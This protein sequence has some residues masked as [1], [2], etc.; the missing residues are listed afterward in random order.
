MIR[1]LNY[2][3][4]VKICRTDLRLGT[5]GS[6]GALSFDA[7]LR[8][9]EYELPADAQVFVE[10]YRQTSWMR[11]PYGTVT[12]IQPPANRLL[13]EFDSPEGIHFRIK[14]T[15][16]GDE[17]VLLAVADRIPLALPEENAEA[18]CLL[19][20]RPAELGNEIWQLDL[21]DP[22]P[23]LLVNHAAAPDWRQMAYS[24]V[25]ISLVYPEVFRQ[26]LLTVLIEHRHRDID[27]NTDWKSKWL[28]FATTL[29]GVDP[30]LP[31]IEGEEE[32]VKIWVTDAVSAFAKKL[33]LKDKF[34]AAWNSTEAK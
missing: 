26:V 9:T 6:D 25:F 30:E 16:A 17:H 18:E 31:A 8:L 19:P 3:G 23:E 20:V 29:P 28:R 14:V 1:R 12:A 22:E 2:T 4:R 15:Q 5:V 11:F 34:I 33:L 10:A 27:D 24:P 13:S 32:A 21:E 7:N